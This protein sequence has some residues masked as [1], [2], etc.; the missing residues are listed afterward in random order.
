M[1]TRNGGF[2]DLIV[3]QRA[4]VLCR[5]ILPVTKVAADRRDYAMAQN[6]NRAALSIMANIAEG[7]LRRSP[8]DFAHFIRIAAGSNGETRACLYAAFDRGYLN[9]ESLKALVSLTNELGRMLEG[10]RSRLALRAREGKLSNP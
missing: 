9:E 5:E 2:E 6:L 4:R 3:W 10:L 7:H 1:T 8:R